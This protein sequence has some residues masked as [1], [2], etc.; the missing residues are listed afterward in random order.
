MLFLFRSPVYSSF[1]A[2]L[3]GLVTLRAYDLREI[4]TSQFHTHINR[5]GRAFF[6]FLMVSRWLGFRLDLLS[7]TV[8]TVASVIA[9]C[10]RNS[11]DIGTLQ[12]FC[13]YLAIN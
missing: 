8:V 1:S 11:V 2:S 12:N 5:N 4:I 7:A 10:L 3:N 13:Y 9:A 6:S